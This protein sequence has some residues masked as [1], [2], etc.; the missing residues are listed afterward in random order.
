MRGIYS[1]EALLVWTFIR[2]GVYCIAETF[3]LVRPAFIKESFHRSN[4]NFLVGAFITR[5]FTRGGVG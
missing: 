4:C 3:L 1:R 5:T 2:E